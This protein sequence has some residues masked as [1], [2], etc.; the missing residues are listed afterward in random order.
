MLLDVAASIAVTEGSDAVSME[1]VAER[2][3]VSRP[4]VYKHFRNRDE[5]LQNVYRRAARRLHAQLSAEVLAAD[6]TE[7]MFRA[8]IHGALTI[9]GE[10]ARIIAALRS[11]TWTRAVRREQRQRDA[12]TTRAFSERIERELGVDRRRARPVVSLLLSTIDMALLHWRSDPTPERA[13]RLEEA[14]MEIVTA[15]L[16]SLA[17]PR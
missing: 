6:T 3:G 17:Q 5:L 9:G 2:A 10:Q 7:G 8:L 12:D 11:G 4:L 13:A 14:Y 16:A 1:G 15:T